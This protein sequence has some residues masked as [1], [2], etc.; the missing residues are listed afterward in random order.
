MRVSAA[1]A[2]DAAMPPAPAIGE[3]GHAILSELGLDAAAIARLAATGA[4]FLPEA[5]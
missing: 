2:A 3:H 1:A 4:V 5:I